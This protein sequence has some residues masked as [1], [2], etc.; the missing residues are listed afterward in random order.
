MTLDVHKALEEHLLF[1]EAEQILHTHT[2]TE[3]GNVP[4]K[5]ATSEPNP[6]FNLSL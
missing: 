2:D 6:L 3:K 5:R 1:T 4:R